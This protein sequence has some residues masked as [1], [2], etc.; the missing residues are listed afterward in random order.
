MKISIIT[1][2]YNSERNILECLES[3]KNQNYENIE[4]II[5]D[6]LSSDSTLEII[7]KNKIDN[8][9]II[10]EKDN[11]IYDAWNKGFKVA[12]GDIIGT[13]MSD[14]FFPNS[15]VVS[16]IASS[17][18]NNNCDILYGNMNFQLNNKIV[19]EWKPGFFKKRSFYFGWMPPPP[20]VYV[21][22][23]I[24]KNNLPFNTN[25]KI[26][27]D[28]EW[29]LRIFFLQNYRIFYL[30]KFTYTLR[31]GGVS[32]KSLKNIIKSN[33][34]CY[35]AWKENEISKFP[36]WVFLKPLSRILQI[37]KFSEIFKFYFR[38]SV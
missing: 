34:E 12:S 20:T 4:H 25:Y 29:L 37:K 17:F 5:I 15:N 22:K 32:N 3:I 31:M 18:K 8:T 7:N 19:R 38:K 6:G 27:G 28:Y 10:S 21:S 14:D 16:D 26:A 30:N 1:L 36:F 24:V 11:G 35:Y 33:L 13:V 23:S 2:T 9:I